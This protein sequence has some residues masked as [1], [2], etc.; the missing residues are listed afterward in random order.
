MSLTQ[1]LPTQESAD[2]KFSPIALVWGALIVFLFALIV[3]RALVGNRSSML[4][5]EGLP[6]YGSIPDLKLV[7]SS[8]EPFSISDLKGKVWV[9]SLFFT[10]CAASCPM[11]ASQLAKFQES[12]DNPDIVLVSISVDPERDTPER[13]REYAKLTGAK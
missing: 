12:V 2:R 11:M 1:T 3:A 4:A 5:L 7:E 9:A 6:V 8:G 13:L 10:H